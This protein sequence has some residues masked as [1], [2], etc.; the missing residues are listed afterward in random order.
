MKKSICKTIFISCL[1]LTICGILDAGEKIR[2]GFF[3][4]D[5]YHMES[6]SPDD[7][8]NVRRSGYGYDFLQLL[9]PYTDWEYI[10]TGYEKDWS[11]MQEMLLNGEID[12]LTSAVKTPEREKIFDFSSRYCKA[13]GL[14]IARQ[15]V[16][17]L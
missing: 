7:P 11:A 16:C 13:T 15:K 4:F 5:G 8:G 2:A 9:V 6:T 17:S 1:I 12:L 3:S 14:L 10:Y